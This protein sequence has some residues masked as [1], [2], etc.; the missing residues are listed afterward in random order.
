MSMSVRAARRGL[1]AWAAA[2]ALV[3]AAGCSLVSVG[4][5]SAPML[6]AWR[7][8]DWFDLD[9][10]QAVLLRARL[11]E[12]HVFHR[13]QL[14]PVLLQRL[15]EAQA[16]LA[17]P[18]TTDDVD[19]AVA[20]LRRHYDATVAQLMERVAP[21]AAT[22]RPEQLVRLEAT[23][24][25]RNRDYAREYLEGSPEDIAAAR[26]ER[27]LDTAED[28]FGR[29]APEQ[30]ALLRERVAAMPA[31]D[32][33]ALA[34]R[35]RRQRELIAIL[36]QARAGEPARLSAAALTRWATDWDSGREPRHRAAREA[37]R[38][39]YARL[40]VDLIN[41]AS[42]AQRAHLRGRLAGYVR[43][44][45]PATRAEISQPAAGVF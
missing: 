13:Q 23:F 12:A 3:L 21:L 16:R 26:Y 36:Q 8:G 38:R 30:R 37:L 25:K 27:S 45:A 15:D 18:V 1:A 24:A 22:L 29:L 4:Y 41:G 28:W 33:A 14:L 5:G 39:S 35:Q 32:A 20:E 44:L 34:D 17:R 43:D 7:A 42:P 11:D 40:Y 19:W 2:L 10:E 31:E 9:A 6:L